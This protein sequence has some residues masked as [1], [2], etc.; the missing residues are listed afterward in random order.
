MQVKSKQNLNQKFQFNGL[1]IRVVIIFRGFCPH[2]PVHGLALLCLSHW[3]LVF[4]LFVRSFPIEEIHRRKYCAWKVAALVKRNYRFNYNY[5]FE[6]LKWIKMF[7]VFFSNWAFY[8]SISCPTDS[9]SSNEMF[10][11]KTSRNTCEDMSLLKWTCVYKDLT[12]DER[13]VWTRPE[14]VTIRYWY[15]WTWTL[16]FINLEQYHFY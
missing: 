15:G 9:N 3:F 7:W 16:W 13:L 10:G 14:K 11:V 2:S 12:P 1:W 4:F 5:N 8:S 6:K